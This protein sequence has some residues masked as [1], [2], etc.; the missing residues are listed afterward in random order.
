MIRNMKLNSYLFFLIVFILI[1][2]STELRILFDHFTFNALYFAFFRHPL[3]FFIIFS[4]PYL[5]KK[6]S[7]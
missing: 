5:Y 1:D 6:L 7:Y 4:Y 3:S 2:M